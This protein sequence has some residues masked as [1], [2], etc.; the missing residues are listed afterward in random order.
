MSARIRPGL[1]VV[2]WR[3]RTTS[4]VI[5]ALGL[6]A[7]AVAGCGVPSDGT[8]RTIDPSSVPYGLLDRSPLAPSPSAPTGVPVTSPRVY[9]VNPEGQL[10]AEERP[11]EATGLD[12]LTRSLLSALD[13]GPTEEQR[14]GGLSSGLG[15]DAQLHLVAVSNGTARI[16]LTPS[17]RIEAADQLPLAMGQ[18]VLT[19]TSIEGVDRVQL[20]QNG[21]PLEAPLPGGEQTSRP[22]NPG[23]YTSLLPETIAQSGKAQPSPTTESVRQRRGP[24]L[25]IS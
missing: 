10:V 21:Q 5:V 8:T 3:R 20:V 7:M 23:D 9:F 19:A 17:T 25:G 15:P 12:Q 14:A 11:M 2:P 22:L 24:S 13:D 16:A 6:T 1:S 4:V 18:I